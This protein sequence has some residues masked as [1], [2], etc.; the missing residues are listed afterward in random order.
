MVPWGRHQ[1]TLTERWEAPKSGQSQEVGKWGAGAMGL[2]PQSR[3]CQGNKALTSI[4]F[5]SPTVCLC[6]SPTS[7][8]LAASVY[9]CFLSFPV[10]PL[11][12]SVSPFCLPRCLFLSLVA[13]PHSHVSDLSAH[14]PVIRFLP[15][16]TL[17]APP[18]LH[19]SLFLSRVLSLAACGSFSLSV[20]RYLSFPSLSV[21][22]PLPPCRGR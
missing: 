20:S 19:L 16:L 18:P 9:V 17:P 13:F 5:L 8:L 11:S 1:N 7:R 4:F 22:D 3:I 15:L 10:Y 6:L 21:S 2:A 12:P 14:L